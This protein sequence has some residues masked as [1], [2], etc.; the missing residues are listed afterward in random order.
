M[1]DEDKNR[2]EEP[3]ESDRSPDDS[4]DELTVDD[5]LAAASDDGQAADDTTAVL[6]STLEERTRDLQRLN[7]E[8]QNYRK[9]VERD[10]SRASEIATGAV[11]ASLL[12][13]L[14]DLDRAREHGDLNGP[15]G[16][17]S[18]QLSAALGKHGLES[19]GEKGDAFDPNVHE[20][21]AHLQ[22]G[23]V[24]GPTCIDVMRRGY[25]LGDRLLRPALVA[26]AEP[27]DEPEP[28]ETEPVE[29]SDADVEETLIEAEPEGAVETAED[30]GDEANAEE[31]PE[32]AD[33]AEAEVA[34]G[35][36]TGP[37]DDNDGSEQDSKGDRKS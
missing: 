20:A 22:M 5:I 19:F 10:K 32:A 35:D 27:L 6:Q 33:E 37:D 34:Q 14:D 31:A 3:P 29:S 18:E 16:A 15:F 4:G 9:R 23:D 25:R 13:I 1:T 26:V 21:V 12:P 36:E 2:S 8:F 28:A 17:V 30:P 24:D 11:L 7:A